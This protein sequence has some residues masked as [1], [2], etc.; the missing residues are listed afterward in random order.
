[1]AIAA[2]IAPSSLQSA[3]QRGKNITLDMLEACASVLGTPL[4]TLV[5]EVDYM[6]VCKICGKPVTAAPVHHPECWEKKIHEV[7]E[8]FCDH[9]CVWPLVCKDE[10]RLAEHHCDHDCPLIQLLNLGL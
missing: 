5:S 7:A 2:G 8:K 4:Y 6:P 1:M 3:L 9:F 10:E